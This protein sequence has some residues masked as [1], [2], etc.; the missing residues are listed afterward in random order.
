VTVTYDGVAEEKIKELRQ[1]I[2]KSNHKGFI[3]KE[4]PGE[5]PYRLA[6]RVVTVDLANSDPRVQHEGRYRVTKWRPKE[7]DATKRLRRSCRYVSNIIHP[8]TKQRLHLKPEKGLKAIKRAPIGYEWTQEDM[9]LQKYA[10]VGPFEFEKQHQ[11]SQ[12]IWNAF[13]REAEVHE[14]DTHPHNAVAPLD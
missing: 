7:E 6:W 2:R 11:I 8:Q 10:L 3:I 9:D 1:S 4:N 12:Q 14:V 13:V 5:P